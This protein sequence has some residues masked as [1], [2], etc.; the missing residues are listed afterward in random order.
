VHA[1]V[2]VAGEP[3]PYDQGEPKPVDLPR[4]EAEPRPADSDGRVARMAAVA[5]MAA[6]KTYQ[7]PKA[8]GLLGSAVIDFLRLLR[9]RGVRRVTVEVDMDTQTVQRIVIGPER[10]RR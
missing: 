4:V 7:T 8:A 6:G 9:A 5:H 10:R 3:M 1:E 2:N